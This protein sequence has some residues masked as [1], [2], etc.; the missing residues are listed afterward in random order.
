MST[1]SVSVDKLN[2][3]NPGTLCETLG[4]EFTAVGSDFVSAKMPVDKRTIQTYGL[5]HGGASVALAETLGSVAS[6]VVAGPENICVGVEINANHL[7]SV[8][9][10][11]V[12]GTAKPIRIGRTLHVWSIE[13]IDEYDNLVCTSRLTVLVKGKNTA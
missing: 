4:I 12:Y 2:E 8:T 1:L 9:E 6:V 3:L 10:G 7:K 5:L 11:Y 13:I